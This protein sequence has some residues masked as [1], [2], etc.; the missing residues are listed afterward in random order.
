MLTSSSQN[1]AFEVGDTFDAL[2]GSLEKGSMID[3]RVRSTAAL[4]PFTS[5]LYL[6]PA[7]TGTHR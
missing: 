3:K 7:A 6:T 5:V 4:A 2:M 1:A